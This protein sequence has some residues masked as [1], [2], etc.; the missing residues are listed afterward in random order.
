MNEDRGGLNSGTRRGGYAC[1]RPTAC[2][3]LLLLA[4]AVLP[5]CSSIALPREDPSGSGDDPAS[6]KLIADYLKGSF[7]D[8]AAYEAFEISGARWVHSL[9][10]W[11]WLTCVRFQD[12]GR[13]R[14][15]AVFI[16]KGAVVDGRYAVESDACDAQT[17]APFPVM[18]E[19]VKPVS[20]G[21]QG[22]LY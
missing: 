3:A 20:P 12:H 14:R 8:H 5:A 11:S 19:G 6:T 4:L 1:S 21:A 16:S 10:G 22:P 17:Y 18:M 2:T 13:A 9:K 15:Y 7:K